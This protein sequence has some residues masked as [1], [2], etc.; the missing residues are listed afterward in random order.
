MLNEVYA[1]EIFG[2]FLERYGFAEWSEKDR[3]FEGK[4]KKR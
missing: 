2:S 1:S 3:R 4:K